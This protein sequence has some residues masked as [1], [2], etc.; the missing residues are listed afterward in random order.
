MHLLFSKS[1]LFRVAAFKWRLSSL[2]LMAVLTLASQGCGIIS[3]TPNRAV[4]T[5]GGIPPSGSQTGSPSSDQP[6]THNPREIPPIAKVPS[7]PQ[8]EQAP[9]IAKI[10]APS[11]PTMMET[12]LAS[13]YGSR[14]HGK[15]TASGEVFNQNK[16]TAAHRTLPWGSRVKVTNLANG[17][18][19][20]V[21][22]ND[23]GPFSQ[24]RI[25]DVSRAAARSL[26]MV[27]QGITT[28]RI[29]CL[30]D[31]EKSNELVLQD[32]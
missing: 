13:W 29:E 26:D 14:H 30:P 15:R 10:P 20:E 27:E 11:E 23:R 18:S 17:K 5:R 6:P 21:R 8:T 4:W 12:G 32:K 22:I 25:I 24:G 28:V 1:L 9:P 2:I 19:V 7:F 3:E 31:S 16:F